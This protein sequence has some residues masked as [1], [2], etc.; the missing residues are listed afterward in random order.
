MKDFTTSEY[1]DPII[2]AY[3][4]LYDP[5]TDKRVLNALHCDLLLQ[6]HHSRDAQAVR[7]GEAFYSH[8]FKDVNSEIDEYAEYASTYKDELSEWKW[9]EKQRVHHAIRDRLLE[10]Y[11]N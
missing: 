4:A 6:S 9:N 8:F 3:K 5:I 1:I 10:M 7:A 11:A 2:A